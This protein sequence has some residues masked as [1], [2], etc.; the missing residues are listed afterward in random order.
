MVSYYCYELE[1]CID[2]W[3][4]YGTGHMNSNSI[5]LIVQTN[6]IFWSRQAENP[7]GMT[8]C[9]VPKHHIWKKT[10]LARRKNNQKVAQHFKSQVKRLK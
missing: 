9:E 4:H 10:C 7:K 8:Y 6:G 2:D 3:M 5:L 1:E